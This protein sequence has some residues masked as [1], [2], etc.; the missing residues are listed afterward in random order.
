MSLDDARNIATI[1]GVFVGALALL[2]GFHEYTQQ[3]R[4]KRAEHFIAMRS[5]FKANPAFIELCD[6]LED[7]DIRLAEMPF[8]KKRDFLGFFEEI[9]IMCNSGL[10]HLG[11]AHY[12]FGYYV[13][14]CW[15]SEHFW[16]GL[17]REANYISLFKDFALQM[18]STEKTFAFDR[19]RL[20]L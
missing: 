12:M 20:R 13:I 8:K 6:F 1:V 3:G 5:R 10:L 7:D 17:D 2:K 4:Q 15:K 19:D 9:A 16:K 14:D 11:I 18:V